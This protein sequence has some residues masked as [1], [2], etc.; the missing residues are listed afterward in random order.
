MRRRSLPAW[1]VACLLLLMLGSAVRP[2]LTIACD[3][4]ALLNAHASSPH[5]HSRDSDPSDAPGTE[6]GEHEEQLAG[7]SNG[8]PMMVLTIEM[9][10]LS[11]SLAPASP[12]ATTRVDAHAGPPFRPPIA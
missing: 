6:H 8:P 9:V 11:G 3:V 4:H 10:A 7:D 5:D 2:F 1:R 12:P